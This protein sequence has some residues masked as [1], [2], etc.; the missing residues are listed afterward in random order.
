V[1]YHRTWVYLAQ[2]FEAEISGTIEPLPGIPPSA[3]HLAT[4]ADVI[5]VREVP[6][7][8]RDP[9]HSSSAVEFLQRETGVR[10]V[11]LPASCEKAT[12][13]SFFEHFDQI[14]STLGRPASVPMSEGSAG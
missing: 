1:E 9:Y 12:V 10:G 4:L 7:V 14:L 3:R 5:Q 8:I 2:R 11:V 13:E 6:V